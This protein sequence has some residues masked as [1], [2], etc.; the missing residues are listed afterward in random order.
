MYWNKPPGRISYYVVRYF[1]EQGDEVLVE[2]TKEPH[3]VLSKDLVGD[4]SV[5]VHVYTYST[6]LQ[7][8]IYNNYYSASGY[9][10]DSCVYVGL[11]CTGWSSR[12]L[13]YDTQTFQ[14]RSGQSDGYVNILICT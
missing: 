3:I 14:K 13:Q 5:Q 6:H 1:N 9:C 2:E 7:V 4:F 8:A 10:S 12:Q 11:F